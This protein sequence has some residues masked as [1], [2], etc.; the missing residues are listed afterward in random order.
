[1]AHDKQL[2]KLTEILNFSTFLAQN[3]HP[4]RDGK[5]EYQLLQVKV[6][7]DWLAVFR[8]AD[9]IVSTPPALRQLIADFGQ[10]DRF[11]PPKSSNV[12]Q[13]APRAAKPEEPEDEFMRDDF[14][15]VALQGML[16]NP[17]VLGK[18]PDGGKAIGPN[19]PTLAAR[20]AYRFADAMIAARIAKAEP[21]PSLS[22]DARQSDAWSSDWKANG[23]NGCMRQASKALRFL[24]NNERPMGGQSEF[25]SEHLLQIAEE[26]DITK[27]ELLAP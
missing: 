6:G 9:G 21:E 13:M 11:S 5:G 27:R 12:V 25:N 15:M 20:E 23:L 4:V 2:L 16:A 1:M 19:T 10:W 18:H 7:K 26:L 22:R 14:A 3:D 24:A 17:N 8:N